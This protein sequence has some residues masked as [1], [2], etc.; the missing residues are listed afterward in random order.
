MI[1]NFAV[2]CGMDYERAVFRHVDTSVG[3]GLFPGVTTGAR[4][5]GHSRAYYGIDGTRIYPDITIENYVDADKECF[6]L[7]VIECKWC[8]SANVRKGQY[9]E[10]ISRLAQFGYKVKGVMVTNCGYSSKTQ[11][12]AAR[13]GVSLALY[14]P[15]GEWKWIVL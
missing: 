9:Y 10:F 5:F 3:K 6:N 15:G 1:G 2:K 11:E 12:S 13:M 7:I 8:R 14:E 4:V